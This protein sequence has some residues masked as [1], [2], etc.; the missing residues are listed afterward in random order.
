MPEALKA[1]RRKANQLEQDIR[2]LKRQLQEFSKINPEE[3]ERLQDAERQK[4]ELEQQRGSRHWAAQA[5]RLLQKVKALQRIR[6]MIISAS[7]FKQLT[8]LDRSC[9]PG[10]S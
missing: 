1:G 7:A 6:M 8:V 9:M 4:V 3:Y 2:V 10:A 5:L